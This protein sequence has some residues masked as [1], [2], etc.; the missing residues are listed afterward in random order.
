MR[1]LSIGNSFSQDAHRYLY[2][3]A[4]S[5]GSKIQ[6][7]NLYIGG[8]SLRTHY[9]NMLEDRADYTLEFNGVSTG[10]KVSIAQALMSND[11][12]VITLQ[13]ASHFS[14]FSDS[15]YPYIEELAAYVRKYCPRAKIYIH[16]TW[17]YENGSQ[18][19]SGLG[20][21]SMDEMYESLSEAYRE[22]AEY[23]SAYGIIP[24]GRAML[25]A[26]HFGIS[27][28]HRDT[29]HASLGAGRYLLGLT[30]YKAIFGKDI[31]EVTF[32]ELDEPIT[33]D[34]R[35]IIVRA[36]NAAFDETDD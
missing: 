30:W 25:N 4:S 33:E 6:L 35:E 14:A 20:F 1:I 16:E 24:S 29:F 12:D 5:M 21:E 3:I 28:V 34:E 8:C 27:R 9:L 22:A 10:F 2:E 18:K 36:V 19:L 7:V 11:F 15:Y 26:V 17:A 13:Q 31:S 23:V 32:I